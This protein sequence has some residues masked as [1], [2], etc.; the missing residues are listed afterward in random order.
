MPAKKV[1][2]KEVNLWMSAG[3]TVT[4]LHMDTSENIMHMVAGRKEFLLFRP[5]QIEHLHYESV[6]EIRYDDTG[7]WAV[8]LV[9]RLSVHLIRLIH[10][11]A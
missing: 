4:S 7:G 5:N 10:V 6:P 2:L 11:F 9:I 3:G 8:L 1:W